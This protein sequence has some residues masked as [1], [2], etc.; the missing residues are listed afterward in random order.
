MMLTSKLKNIFPTF[1]MKFWPSTPCHTASQGQRDY[2]A[3]ILESHASQ[4]DPRHHRPANITNYI[5]G[6]FTTLSK[7]MV[8]TSLFHHSR[9]IVPLQEQKQRR[10]YRYHCIHDSKPSR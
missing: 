3:V 7:A 9:L 4:D 1:F 2:S 6:Q 5:G 10:K 8:H